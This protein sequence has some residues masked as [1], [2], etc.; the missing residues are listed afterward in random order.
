LE[1]SKK[2]IDRNLD[3]QKEKDKGFKSSEHDCKNEFKGNSRNGID[4]N[5]SSS[6]IKFFFILKWFIDVS[7]NK[8]INGSIPF[9][10]KFNIASSIPPV[11]E[12]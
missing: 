8:V 9:S 1:K 12:K 5:K 11:S 6:F 10:H 7:N 3:E 4:I 2:L